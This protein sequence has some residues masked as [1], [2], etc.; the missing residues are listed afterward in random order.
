M[1]N[2]DDYSPYE[3]AIIRVVPRVERG[4]QIN[5]GV[6]LFCRQR[7][8]LAARTG[9]E[10]HHRIALSALAPD[11]DLDAISERLNLIVKICDG[12]EGS[13]PVGQLSQAER[14]RWVVAPSSTTVQASAVHGGRCT[15]PAS[16][17]DRLY[18]STVA[19]VKGDFSHSSCV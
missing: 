8:F 17:L 18:R 11:L 9:L 15:D 5:V 14:F 19:A 2:L 7:R 13:G 1:N 10:S 4:E 16:E 12:G 6:V 3:Y